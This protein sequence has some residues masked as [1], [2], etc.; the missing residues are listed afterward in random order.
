MY[1]QISYEKPL[2]FIKKDIGITHSV[3]DVRKEEIK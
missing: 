2:W 3:G 1:S